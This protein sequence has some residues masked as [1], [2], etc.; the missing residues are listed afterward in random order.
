M[1]R[2]TAKTDNNIT[3]LFCYVNVLVPSRGFEPLTLARHGPKP[4]AYA[5]SATRASID[6]IVLEWYNYNRIVGLCQDT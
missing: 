1:P 6:F 5:S 2:H 3:I 4:C